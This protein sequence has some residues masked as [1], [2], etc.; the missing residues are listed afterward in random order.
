MYC[1]KCKTVFEDDHCPTC[2]SKD[3][4]T[5]LPDDPC[6]LTEKKGTWSGM[7]EDVLSQNHI[8]VLSQSTMGAGMATSVGPL[9]EKFRIYVRY[10]DLERAKDIVNELFS[11]DGD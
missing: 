3:V 7:L 11:K 5:P 2:G 8:S 6:F 10:E 9:F 1:E 4:R